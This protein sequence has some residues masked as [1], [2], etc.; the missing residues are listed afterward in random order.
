M[1]ISTSTVMR[2]DECG[3]ESPNDY[4]YGQKNWR[5]F[6]A[7]VEGEQAREYHLCSAECHKEFRRENPDVEL[8]NLRA[9]SS[10]SQEFR[11]MLRR[12]EN[13]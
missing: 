13:G 11:D 9:V 1:S 12:A 10:L 4:Y 7:S 3:Y 5:I 2:C 6:T 8:S